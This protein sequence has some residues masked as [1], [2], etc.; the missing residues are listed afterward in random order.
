MRSVIVALFGLALA[1]VDGADLE[2]PKNVSAKERK[3]MEAAKKKS[4]VTDVKLKKNQS[5][6][7]SSCQKKKIWSLQAL[8]K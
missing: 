8:R 3:A 7:C 6:I 2:A 5:T 1:G 4:K